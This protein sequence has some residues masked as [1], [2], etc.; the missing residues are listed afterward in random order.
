MGTRVEVIPRSTVLEHKSTV[1]S[2]SSF[3]PCGREVQL[4][5]GGAGMRS[6]SMVMTTPSISSVP[7]W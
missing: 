6:R 5:G 1:M 7:A 4:P 2:G 3:P